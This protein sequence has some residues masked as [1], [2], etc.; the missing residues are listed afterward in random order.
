M[1]DEA[2]RRKT[3]AHAMAHAAAAVQEDARKPLPLAP[4][5][6]TPGASIVWY[7]I[8]RAVTRDHFHPGDYRTLGAYCEAA[9]LVERLSA[10]LDTEQAVV[11]DEETGK[12]KTNPYFSAF[13]AAVNS[14]QGLAVRLKL[15]PSTRTK[16]AASS[17]RASSMIA[18]RRASVR[19]GLMYGDGTPP[20]REPDQ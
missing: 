12:T 14:V 19:P 1:S 10:D 8:M 7:E 3:D 9:A 11:T 5:Y 4:A 13:Y 18:A 2:D 17:K 20:Q 15:A 6:L 16:D